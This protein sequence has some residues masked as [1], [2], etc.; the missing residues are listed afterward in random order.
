MYCGRLV[1]CL[2]SDCLSGSWFVYPL[3]CLTVFSQSYSSV[4]HLFS[5]LHAVSPSQ[6]PFLLIPL[7]SSF[8]LLSLLSQPLVLNSPFVKILYILPDQLTSLLTLVNLKPS[9]FIRLPRHL[10][11]PFPFSYNSLPRFPINFFVFTCFV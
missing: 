9:A 10:S 6:H 8:P 1:N 5:P 2:M 4:L 7:L 11:F 3:S